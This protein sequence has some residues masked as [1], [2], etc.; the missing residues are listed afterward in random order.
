MKNP[1][2]LNQMKAGNSKDQIMLGDYP[3]ALSEAIMNTI[4]TNKDISAKLLND[5]AIYDKFARAML[6]VFM[7]NLNK[8]MA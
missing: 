8:G 6:N 4:N 2:V 3:K 5:E 1:E 7:Q